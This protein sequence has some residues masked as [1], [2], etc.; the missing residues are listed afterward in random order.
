[1]WLT[2]SACQHKTLCD[3]LQLAARLRTVGMLRREAE[4][5]YDMIDALVLDASRKMACDKCGHVGLKVILADDLDEDDWGSGTWGEARKCERC[6]K[7]IPAERLEVFPN[8][9]L[10][11]TCQS[12][13]DS[14]AAD[15]E[16]P[17]YC[18]RCGSLMEMRRSTGTGISRYQMVCTGCGT[19]A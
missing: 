8:S 3:E 14:G 9:K 1:M 16:E 15:D 13:A 6:C 19:R 7:I 4:P 10:C 12:Q 17:E 11:A 18:R 5:S 2:C